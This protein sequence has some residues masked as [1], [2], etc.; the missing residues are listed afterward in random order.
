MSTPAIVKFITFGEKKSYEYDPINTMP[1][2]KHEGGSIK[3]WRRFP[4][5]VTEGLMN[6]AINDSVKRSEDIVQNRTHTVNI[7]TG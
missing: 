2:V 6:G 7:S 1:T 5:N 4:V 3:T